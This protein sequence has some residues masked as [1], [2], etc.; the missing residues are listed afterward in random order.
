M[1]VKKAHVFLI[2]FL[3]VAALLIAYAFTFGKQ[4]GATP[5]I[6]EELEAGMMNYCRVIRRQFGIDCNEIQGAGAAGGPSSLKL[7]TATSW[8]TAK[9]NRKIPFRFTQTFLEK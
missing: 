4:K 5:A 7:F 1:K 9:S 8:P 2:V 6:Q 3:A